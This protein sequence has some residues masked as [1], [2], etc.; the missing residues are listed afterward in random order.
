MTKE[1]LILISSSQ[2]VLQSTAS[3]TAI[4]FLQPAEFK[5]VSKCLVHQPIRILLFYVSIFLVSGKREG[6]EN[7]REKPRIDKVYVHY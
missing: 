1:S 2:T 6:E 4:F 7:K 5:P 3:S